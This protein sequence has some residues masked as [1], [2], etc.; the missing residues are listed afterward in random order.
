MS[1]WD[2]ENN[3]PLDFIIPILTKFAVQS[4]RVEAESFNKNAWCN[5]Q[6]QIKVLMSMNFLFDHI[7]LQSSF[8]RTNNRLWK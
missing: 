5:K 4:E 1:V 6:L 7:F 2:S 8:K 3:V